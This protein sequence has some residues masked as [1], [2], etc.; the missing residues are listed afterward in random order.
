MIACRK[1]ER[2]RCRAA[3]CRVAHDS[4]GSECTRVVFVNSCAFDAADQPTAALADK[5][6]TRLHGG[7]RQADSNSR[8]T[9]APRSPTLRRTSHP[10]PTGRRAPAH[11]SAWR[12]CSARRPPWSCCCAAR[13]GRARSA[14]RRLRCFA[15]STEAAPSP[16]RSRA[17]EMQCGVEGRTVPSRPPRGGWV[18]RT[19]AGR[20]GGAA[21]A[22]GKGVDDVMMMMPVPL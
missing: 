14:K 6:R 11:R 9:N 4:N 13:A 12:C 2:H 3:R 21:S 17:T 1:A 8:Q 16:S 20:D 5:P 22:M 18:V 19:R 7:D 15:T 10:R